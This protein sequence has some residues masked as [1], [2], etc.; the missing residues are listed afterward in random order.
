M[1]ALGQ[2]KNGL[3]VEEFAR[4]LDQETTDNVRAASVAKTSARLTALSKI[5]SDSEKA[6]DYGAEVKSATLA[7]LGTLLQQFETQC[8]A[9]G[10]RVHWALNGQEAN[11]IAVELCQ[12]HCGEVKTVAKAKSMATEE[13]HLN[14]ALEKAG[15]EP[16]E[17][18]LGEFVIQADDD[19]PSHIVTPL[20]HKNRRQIAATFKRLNL[21]PY[22]EVPEELAAQARLHLR[23]KFAEARVGISGVNFGVAS[24]GRMVLVENEGNNRLSTTVPDVHIAVMGIEKLVPNEESLAILLPLLS[25]SATGQR[26]PTYVHFIQGPRR[27]GETDGPRE[28]HLILLDN[29]RTDV[30]NGKYREVLR[31]IRCGACQNVCPVYRQ[32]GGHAYGHVYSGPIGAVLAPALEGV[33]KMGDLAWASSLCGA[34]E[35]VCPVKIPLPSMLLHLRDDAYRAGVSPTHIAWNGFTA[36][37]TRSLIWNTGLK[38]LPMASLAPHPLKTKWLEYRALPKA[39]GRAF[40]KWWHDRS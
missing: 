22:T 6:R 39:E 24:T 12:K 14:M 4:T 31:C 2:G 16:V 5:F 34:C 27:S 19:T 20:I 8:L 38:L 28:V 15:F 36:V 32:A 26:L 25:G 40:R 1:S 35:E 7:N 13:I 30:L 23:Q 37:A 21:G 3:R 17:T 33:E 18:D 9:N 29:G 11:R 10:I